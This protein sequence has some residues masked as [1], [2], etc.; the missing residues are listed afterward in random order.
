[1]QGLRLRDAEAETGE[2][3]RGG[4]MDRMEAAANA[5]QVAEEVDGYRNAVQKV[6]ASFRARKKKVIG[7]SREAGWWTPSSVIAWIALDRGSP[8]LGQANTHKLS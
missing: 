8:M 4:E 3:E 2:V 6:V 7:R 1:M 5:M